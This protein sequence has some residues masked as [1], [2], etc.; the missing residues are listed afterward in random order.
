MTEKKSGPNIVKLV[1]VLTL[2]SAVVAAVLG[3]VNAITKDRIAAITEE[4]TNSA[5]AEV[6]PV[7]EG[8]SYTELDY[9]GAST[10][11]HVWEAPTGHVVELVVSGAQ[12]MVDLVVGVDN[13]GVVFGQEAD[14][15]VSRNRLTA[16][17]YAVLPLA[18]LA[19]FRGDLSAVILD[20]FV[21]GED[22]LEVFRTQDAET[23]PEEE[24]LGIPEL[25]VIQGG[26]CVGSAR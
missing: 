11:T 15:R 6:L 2:V 13:D 19:V 25:T 21:F 7:A 22:F 18:C 14:Y 10:I 12:S 23:D 9:S 17:S 4:K 26:A 1:V 16:L 24:L 3:G 5:L 8:E 20:E